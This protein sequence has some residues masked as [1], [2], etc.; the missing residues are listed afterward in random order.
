MR[1]REETA[2]RRRYLSL[3]SFKENIPH[4]FLSPY[5]TTFDKVRWIFFSKTT[6]FI[7]FI[8]SLTIVFNNPSLTIVYLFINEKNQKLFFKTLVFLHN[9]IKLPF[10]NLWL[11]DEQI[12][13]FIIEIKKNNCFLKANGK[14]QK[15]NIRSKSHFISQ[16]DR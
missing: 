8:D 1:R 6:V 4:N 5:K 11:V 2:W 7:K 15:S 12:I 13:S 9:R 10:R 3:S 14:K 16:S